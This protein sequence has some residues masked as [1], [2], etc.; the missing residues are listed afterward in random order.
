MA[1]ISMCSKNDCPSFEKCYRAQATANE[2]QAYGMF[3]NAGESC[4]DDYVPVSP[5]RD[6][7]LVPPKP[8]KPYPAAPANGQA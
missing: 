8:C 3:D 6:A 5:S 2:W 4:C 1:D 7:G